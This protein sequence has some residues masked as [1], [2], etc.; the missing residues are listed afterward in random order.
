MFVC[1]VL[2][3][4]RQDEACRRQRQTHKTQEKEEKRR[5]SQMIK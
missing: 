2:L 3:G 5:Y 4:V 1:G